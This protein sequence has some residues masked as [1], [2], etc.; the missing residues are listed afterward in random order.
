MPDGS[1]TEIEV[2][3]EDALTMDRKGFAKLYRR[4]VHGAKRREAYAWADKQIEIR[5]KALAS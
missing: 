3:Y 1:S 2:P 5:E 4:T